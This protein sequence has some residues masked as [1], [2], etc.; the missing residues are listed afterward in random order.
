[1]CMILEGSPNESFD[2]IV[3]MCVEYIPTGEF[4][5]WTDIRTSPIDPTTNMVVRKMISKHPKSV[6]AGEVTPDI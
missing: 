3:D 4:T 5:K 1:M 2:L 6:F